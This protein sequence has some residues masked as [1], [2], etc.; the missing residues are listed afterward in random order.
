[1][2]PAGGLLSDVAA[3]SSTAYQLSVPVNIACATPAAMNS[4]MPLPMPHLDITSSKRN[5]R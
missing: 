5:M 3:L 2:V 1:M 4:D